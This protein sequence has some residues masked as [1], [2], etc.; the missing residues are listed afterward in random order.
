MNIEKKKHSLD[1]LGQIVLVCIRFV[2]TTFGAEKFRLGRVTKVASFSSFVPL[3]V[4]SSGE[5]VLAPSTGATSV[6]AAHIHVH[7]L[8]RLTYSFK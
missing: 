2:T 4:G 5:G 6:V 3:I 1:V 7:T 8:S